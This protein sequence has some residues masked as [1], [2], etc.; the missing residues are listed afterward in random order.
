[1][2]NG[3]VRIKQAL[4]LAGDLLM[5]FTALLLGLMIR[6]RTINISEHWNA[7]ATAFGMLFAV[8]VVIL[9]VN[10]AYDLRRAKNTIV[11]FQNISL[12]FLVNFF[13]GLAFFYFIPAF[14]ITPKTNLILVVLLAT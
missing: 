2:S 3:I 11:L 1:M 4:L 9:F 14:R 6:Y 8:W 7:H 12:S 10:N 13:L 5:M